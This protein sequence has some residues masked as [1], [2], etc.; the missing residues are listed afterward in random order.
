MREAKIKN[1]EIL[2]RY[3]PLGNSWANTLTEITGMLW[4]SKSEGLNDPFDGLGYSFEYDRILKD[5]DRKI[6]IKNIWSVACFTTKW[7]NPTMWAHY[8]NNYTGICLGYDKNEIVKKVDEINEKSNQPS[9]SIKGAF[10]KPMKY[11]QSIPQT[12]RSI[13]EPLTIKTKHWE[14]EDEWRLGLLKTYGN[15]NTKDKGAPSLIKNALREIIYTGTLKRNE[16]VTIRRMA[17]LSDN[18]I[19]FFKIHIERGMRIMT[20]EEV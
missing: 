16:L 20:R 3:R 17:K 18:P 14:Y 11:E 19:K 8:A 13:E 7:D 15:A 5:E 10:L 12:F 4:F 6:P 9:Y 2:Y 1:P